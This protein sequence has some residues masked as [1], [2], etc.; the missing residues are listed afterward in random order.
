M[1]PKQRDIMLLSVVAIDAIDK[2]LQDT[3]VEA[4][5][6]MRQR[7]NTAKTYF[8][9]IVK[10]YMPMFQLE[11]SDVTRIQNKLREAEQKQAPLRKN[12]NI[13]MELTEQDKDLIIVVETIVLELE[14]TAQ[15]SK[16]LSKED[17]KHINMINGYWN[18]WAKYV[19]NL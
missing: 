4:D 1:M 2:Y 16:A 14:A 3:E 18:S 15:K 13:S 5:S 12:G 6:K 17:H 9:K 11:K 7:L 19:Y 10:S 8:D